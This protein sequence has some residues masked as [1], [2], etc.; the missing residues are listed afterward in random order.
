MTYLVKS[1]LS[2]IVS[3]L[4]NNNVTFDELFAVRDNEL[5]LLLQF[6]QEDLIQVETLVAMDRVLNFFARWD[7]NVEDDIFYP[8]VRKRIKKYE[9]F[10][11]VDVSKI[12][13]LMKEVFT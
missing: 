11:N 7:K 5:P 2:N 9:G 12:K 8:I 1:D 3:Y 10:V 13:S 4:D 6:Q